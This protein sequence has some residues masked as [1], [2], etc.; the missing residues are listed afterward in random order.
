[1][2]RVSLVVVL[3]FFPYQQVQRFNRLGIQVPVVL[4]RIVACILSL[5]NT[6]P[7]FRHHWTDQRKLKMRV[8]WYS[9]LLQPPIHAGRTITIGLYTHAHF[10]INKDFGSRL[11]GVNYSEN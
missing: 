10:Y 8:E 9:S 5:R 2:F 11:S 7:I 4:V 3:I 1:M 6:Y